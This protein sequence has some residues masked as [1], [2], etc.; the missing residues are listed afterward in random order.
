MSRRK[1]KKSKAAQNTTVIGLSPFRTSANSTDSA[2]SARMPGIANTDSDASVAPEIEQLQSNADWS[3]IRNLPVG[4]L[5]VDPKYQRMLNGTWVKEIVDQFEPKLLDVIQVSYRGGHYWVFDGQH[6]KNAVEIKFKDPNFPVACRVYHGL[7]ENDEARLFVLLNIKK[8]KMSSASMLK[9]QA[10]YGDEN[11]E[12]F[13]EISNNSGFI[14]DCTKR[15]NRKYG[16]QA[17]R[18]AQRCFEI[19]GETQ[20]ERMLRILYLTWDG[21]QWSISQ[22]MLGGMSLFIQTFGDKMDDGKFVAQLQNVTNSQ[23]TRE[24]GRYSEESV[25][26]AYASALVSFYNKGLHKGKLRRAL[27]LE[28]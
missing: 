7:S 24:A 3:E 14:I 1:S 15:V 4:L 8:K 19:L 11:V 27:L 9:A 26:V 23:I 6:R 12:K 18:K 22:N 2:E 21:E 16:I 17:V 25:A 20:Y 13:L 5:E 10:L 28:D